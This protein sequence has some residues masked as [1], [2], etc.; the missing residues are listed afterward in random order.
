MQKFSLDPTEIRIPSAVRWYWQLST[1]K[2]AEL[3]NLL[4]TDHEKQAQPEQAENFL[5]L[6]HSVCERAL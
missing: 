3:V 1:T 2:W 5:H 4:Q 6:D